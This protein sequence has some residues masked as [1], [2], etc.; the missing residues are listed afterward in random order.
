[1]SARDPI[2]VIDE[3]LT[4]VPSD[5]QWERLRDRLT[6]VRETAHYQPPDDQSRTWSMLQWVLVGELGTEPRTDW[7]IAI[8]DIVQ[9]RRTL[10]AKGETT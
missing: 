8:S 6:S 2:A 7:Q 5:P 10:P 9:G 1:M 3:I 4:H